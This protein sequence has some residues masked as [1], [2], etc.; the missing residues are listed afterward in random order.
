MVV[1]RLRRGGHCMR[2]PTRGWHRAQSRYSPP[3]R[4]VTVGWWR[5]RSAYEGRGRG[6]EAATP[7]V[8]GEAVG[9]NRPPYI[10]PRGTLWNSAQQRLVTSPWLP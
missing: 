3:H 10:G 7:L 6:E 4:W 8:A 1:V 5:Q 2:S 9:H